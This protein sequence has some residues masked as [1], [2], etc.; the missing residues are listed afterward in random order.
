MPKTATDFNYALK[1][2]KYNIG[3]AWEVRYMQAEPE[4]HGMNEP[5]HC[6]FRQ[7]IAA[8]Y[9]AHIRRAAFRRDD[10]H[11]SC[12]NRVKSY[13]LMFAS[14][15]AV[16]FGNFRTSQRS[17]ST[18]SDPVARRTCTN[19]FCNDGRS[20]VRFRAP[21]LQTEHPLRATVSREKCVP[22]VFYSLRP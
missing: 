8:S 3:F 13:L 18:W 12:S 21:S 19:S 16:C 6:H 14:V 10:I 22:L 4:T 5:P 1:P 20:M 9:E 17:T 11:K 15:S 2:G 7:S